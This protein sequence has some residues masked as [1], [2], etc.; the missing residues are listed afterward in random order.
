MNLNDPADGARWRCPLKMP[1]KAEDIP[2]HPCYND[3][4]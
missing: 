2:R 1:L 3:A 4:V